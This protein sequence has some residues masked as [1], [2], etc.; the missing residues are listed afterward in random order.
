MDIMPGEKIG[1][2][3]RTGAGKSSIMTALY[4]IVELEEGSISIDGVDISTLGLKRLRQALAIIPQDALLCRWLYYPALD[5]G[6]TW[7]SSVSG[8]VRSNLDPFNIHDDATLWDALR[9]AYLV[10][11]TKTEN[12][13]ARNEK[14]HLDFPIEDE[15]SNLSIGQ[16]SL[17]SLAR[18]LVTESKI[19]ILDEATGSYTRPFYISLELSHCGLAS[20]DYETD[21]KIQDTIADEFH[22]RTILCIARESISS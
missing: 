18:A 20:V 12:D 7:S 11:T 22:D 5:I 2:V 15:G 17:L 10:E 19:L 14:F 21:R 13:E 16:R 6:L 8:T 1:I 9:R 4:R 3:G